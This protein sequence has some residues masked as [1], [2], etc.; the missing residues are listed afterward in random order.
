MPLP[1]FWQTKTGSTGGHIKPAPA[2]CLVT[3]APSLPNE[4]REVEPS[5]TAP[6]VAPSVAPGIEGAGVDLSKAL[7]VSL[8]MTMR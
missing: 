1:D 6:A 2:V 5:K 7:N 4:F 8:P 3:A